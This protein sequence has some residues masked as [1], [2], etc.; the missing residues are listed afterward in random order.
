MRCAVVGHVEWV[1]FARVSELP[2]S[3][4]IVHASEVYDEPGGGGAIVAR[5]LALLAGRC[6]LFTALGDDALGHAAQRRLAELGIDVH[7]RFAGS[8]RRAW[9]H[10]DEQG[11]RTITVLGAKLLPDAPLPLEGYDLVFFISGTEAAL[12]AARAA[13]F[14]AATVRELPTLQAAG[15]PIDLLVASA[16]D[17]RERYDGSLDVAT[18]IVTDGERGGTANGERYDAIPPVRVV[19]TY[20]AGDSFAAAVAFALA[21]RDSLRNALELGARAGSA[22]VEGR[23]PYSTQLAFVG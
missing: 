12:R 22:V 11:E 18:V 3:G 16:N 20:G 6:E 19:D 8:T 1:E 17:P 14:L 10:V 21:R 4:T 15:V 13:R 7:A 5:Q 23:G 9:T 2:R